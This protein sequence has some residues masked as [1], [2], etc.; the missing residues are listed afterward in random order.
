MECQSRLVSQP[1]FLV[2]Q[3]LELL[4]SKVLERPAV[5]EK[6]GRAGYVERAG[7]VQVLLHVRNDLGCR[8]L[9]SGFCHA[10]ACPV[11]LHPIVSH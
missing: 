9:I 1:D 3:R 2:Y 4:E 6:T 5:H 11:E 8:E 10:Q 7:V